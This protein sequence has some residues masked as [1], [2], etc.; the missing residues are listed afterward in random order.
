MLDNY[1][2]LFEKG[3]FKYNP[4]DKLA[5]ASNA[6]NKPG[7]FIIIAI[8]NQHEEIKFI[9]SSGAMSQSGGFGSNLLKQ[10]I[11]VRRDGSDR[12][13]FLKHKLKSEH[14]ESYRFEWMVTF[15]MESKK[16]PKAIES[17][18]MQRFYDKYQKLPSWNKEY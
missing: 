16:I 6:P 17:E 7:V 15:D 12:E 5:I 2:D 3:F 9:G 13:H 8:E 14:L 1:P 10:R 11:L 4:N 18:L